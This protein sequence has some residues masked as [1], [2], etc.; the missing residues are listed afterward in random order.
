MGS[1]TVNLKRTAFVI[2][3]AL[4]ILILVAMPAWSSVG[5]VGNRNIQAS[6]CSAHSSASPATITMSA[7]KT[8]VA[9]G[10]Q[11]TVD[12]GVSGGSSLKMGVA[13]LS[14]T[15]GSTG[16]TPG[17][18]GWTIVSDPAGGAFNYVEKDYTGTLT[19][20]WTLKAPSTAGT[21]KLYAK[22]FHGN[23]AYVKLYSTGLTIT[24]AAAVVNPPTVTITSP[25]TG[26]TI[27]GTASVSATITADTGQTISKAELSMD[28]TLVGTLTA[29]PYTWSL[30]TTAYANGQHT[31]TV[32]GYDGGGRTGTSSVTVTTSNTFT[33]P[34]VSITAPSN[35]AT[36]SGTVS[37]TASVIMG[38][39]QTITGVDLRVDGVL[40]S[41]DTTSPYSW[42]WNTISYANGAHTLNATVTDGGG[43]T[44]QSQIS[45]TV[46]N[47]PTPPTVAIK[48][49]TSGATVGGVI[50]VTA[51]AAGTGGRTIAT[52]TLSVDGASAGTLTA[53]PY[54]WSVDTYLLNKGA[55]TLNVTATDSIGQVASSVISVTVNNDAPALSITSPT[56]GT[57]VSGSILIQVSATTATGSPSVTM[58][59]DG[60]SIGTISAAPYQWTVDTTTLTDGVHMWSFEAV[61]SKGNS[62]KSSLTLTVSNQGPTISLIA[63]TSLTGLTGMVNITAQAT[64]TAGINNTKLYLDGKLLNQSS[65][66]LVSYELN[67]QNYQSVHVLNV[68]A[69]D[70]LGRNASRSFDL[71]F[72]VAGLSFIGDYSSLTGVVDIVVNVTGAENAANATLYIDGVAQGTLPGP[73]F[74]WTVD[75]ST[76]SDGDHV[77]NVT[78]TAGGKTISNGFTA[79]VVNEPAAP[80]PKL[81]VS[82]VDMMIAMV[83]VVII[84]LGLVMRRGRDGK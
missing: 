22:I 70:N 81:D 61:S 79:T 50:S 55:H 78:A 40:L 35:A 65:S 13:L 67:A 32:T 69:T 25:A 30:D 64:G 54:S 68:T 3:A 43:L 73:A 21:Y 84:T 42:S 53:A 8:S 52:V 29:S 1:H 82:G 33:P 36:V 27:S 38:T 83:F 63:P 58:F 57:I 44:A 37:V 15:T 9:P 16:T 24:V 51:D 6:D 45:V 77:F 47:A 41:K 14:K 80:P 49:P 2:G 71:D 66:G 59:I 4:A 62:S 31:L 5:G 72:S 11:I 17:E 60:T 12:V 74:S 23:A 48:T 76:L 26:A 56:N 7:S 39:S 20:T 18:N 75:T 46:N 10:E 19:D 34:T 28:G